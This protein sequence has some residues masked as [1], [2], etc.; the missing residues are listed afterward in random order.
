MADVCLSLR[1]LTKRFGSIVAVDYVG[2]DVVDGEFI[3]LLGPSGSG[4][5]TCLMMVAGLVEPTAGDILLWGERIND[6]PP[7]KRGIGVVFQQYALFPHMTVHDNIAYPLVMRRVSKQEIHER[8]ES[9]LGLV[10]LG[11]MGTRLPRQ[12]SGGEQQRVALARA[13]VFN[14]KIL[15][16]DEPLGALDRKLRLR[17]QREVRAIQ[18]ELGVTLLYV[19]HDQEEAMTMSDRIAVMQDGRIEQ[20]DTPQSIYERPANRFVASFLGEINFFTGPAVQVD[21]AWVA[22]DLESHICLKAK[23]AP[24]H[25]GQEVTVSVRPEK[26]HFLRSGEQADNCLS[27]AIVRRTF[28]GEIWEY[29]VQLAS[30]QEIKVRLSNAPDE[31]LPMEKEVVHIGWSIDNTLVV[32]IR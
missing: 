21:Q 12:L 13:L 11:G 6:L 32:E 25:I 15:L 29:H 1:N 18:Q 31:Y 22:I 20:L 28:I 16:M 26:M 5:T 30:G 10:Q 27:G 8:V 4:K 17:L 24:L 19:T 14:P 9:V 3:T 7:H 2:L 23:H